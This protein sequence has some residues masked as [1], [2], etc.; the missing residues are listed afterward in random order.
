VDIPRPVA[1]HPAILSENEAVE[2]LTKVLDHIIALGLAV[3]EKV[4]ARFFLEADDTLDLLL[5]EVLVLL[6][7]DLALAKLGTR[8][9]DLFCLLPRTMSGPG[10]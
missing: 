2:E 4:K 5:Q 9:T 3:D 8:L 6:L 7:G 1:L 10:D